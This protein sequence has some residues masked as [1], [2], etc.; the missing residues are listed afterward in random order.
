MV[1]QVQPPEPQPT[2]DQVSTP[3]V[4]YMMNKVDDCNALVQILIKASQKEPLEHLELVME[5]LLKSRKDL[6]DILPTITMLPETAVH[7]QNFLSFLDGQVLHYRKMITNKKLL[8][9][10]K[11][12]ALF[13]GNKD[14]ENLNG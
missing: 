14:K 10:Q 1:M 8:Q 9:N 5:E 7:M 3:N 13:L 4:K 11:I 6:W 12:N 2:Q